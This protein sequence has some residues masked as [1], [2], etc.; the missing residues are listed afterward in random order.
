MKFK[1][2]TRT[3]S[4]FVPFGN[5]IILVKFK[6]PNPA[7]RQC[8]LTPLSQ[9]ASIN[10]CD[11]PLRVNLLVLMSLTDRWESTC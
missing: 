11:R 1:L 2:Q 9:P 6:V 4:N 8:S 10:V 3:P 5:S 7:G